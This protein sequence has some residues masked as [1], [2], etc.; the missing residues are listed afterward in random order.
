M[1][2]SMTWHSRPCVHILCIML[3]AA[4]FWLHNRLQPPKANHRYWV[5]LCLHLEPC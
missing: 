5:K 2:C 3:M 4:K 1:H